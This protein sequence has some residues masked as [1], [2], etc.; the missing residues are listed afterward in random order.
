MLD[1]F[2]LWRLKKV[3]LTNRKLYESWTIEMYFFFKGEKKSA[4]VP[5]TIHFKQLYYDH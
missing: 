4:I 1:Q 5:Q 2:I 3:M